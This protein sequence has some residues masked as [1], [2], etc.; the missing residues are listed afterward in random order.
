MENTMDH[1]M[2]ELAAARNRFNQQTA[3]LKDTER[4][5]KYA[6]DHKLDNLAASAAAKAHRQRLSLTETQA[7]LA[8]L[9]KAT[10]ALPLNDPNKAKGRS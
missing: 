1:L 10:G 9:E 5:V 4:T 7:V 6:Q 3:A 2:K 8:D